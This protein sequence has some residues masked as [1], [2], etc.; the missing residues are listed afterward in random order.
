MTI[1][2]NTRRANRW[3][4]IALAVF[5]VG[6]CVLVFLWMRHRIAGEG[7]VVYP[8]ATILLSSGQNSDSFPQP[9]ILS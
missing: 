1:D 4:M 5:A 3:L 7:G 8:P 9:R 2:P 6:L